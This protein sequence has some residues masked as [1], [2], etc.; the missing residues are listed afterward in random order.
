MSGLVVLPAR[1]VAGCDYV[2][3]MAALPAAARAGYRH[4]RRIVRFYAE[5]CQMGGEMADRALAGA[6]G[7]NRGPQTGWGFV[8]VE[9]KQWKQ[10]MGGEEA[11]RKVGHKATCKY[12]LDLIVN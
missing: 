12:F 4:S 1:P 3:H 6:K 2:V 5:L 10:M 8:Y 9:L 7:F 11:W